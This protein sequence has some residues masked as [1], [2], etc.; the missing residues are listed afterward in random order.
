LS[1]EKEETKTK[2]KHCRKRWHFKVNCLKVSKAGEMRL[3][4]AAAAAAAEVAAEARSI[5]DR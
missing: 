4:S 1:E 5:E 3:V 2:Q